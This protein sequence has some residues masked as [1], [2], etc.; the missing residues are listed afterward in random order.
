LFALSASFGGI[1]IG[2][3]DL[4]QIGQQRDDDRYSN[5][6]IPDLVQKK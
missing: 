5:N 4:K 6:A 2:N 3:S 1:A